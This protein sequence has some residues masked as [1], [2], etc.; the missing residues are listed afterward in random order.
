MKK[1]SIQIQLWGRVQGVGFRWATK[2]LADKIGIFGNVANLSDGSVKILAQ[3]DTTQIDIFIQSLKTLRS[4]LARVE[5]VKVSEVD[6]ELQKEKF[7]IL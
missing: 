4:P 7:L 1:N 3:G 6:Y 5:T 2:Q